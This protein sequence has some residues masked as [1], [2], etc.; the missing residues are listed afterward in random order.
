M[1]GPSLDINP[2]AYEYVWPHHD[3]RAS[4]QTVHENAAVP[5]VYRDLPTHAGRT[6]PQ[7][8]LPSCIICDARMEQKGSLSRLWSGRSACSSSGNLIF[9]LSFAKQ[10]SDQALGRLGA[11]APR[12]AK[13]RVTFDNRPLHCNFQLEL[14]TYWYSSASGFGEYAG[15]SEGSEK[16]SALAVDDVTVPR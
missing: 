11:A 4:I 13:P 16:G 8:N 1:A 14:R 2:P 6:C 12:P 3:T 15:R 7:Q 5:R 9:T 10:D